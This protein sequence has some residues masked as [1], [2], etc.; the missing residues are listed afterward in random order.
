MK[1]AFELVAEFRDAQGKG[2]SRRLRHANKVPA[3]LY[4][5]HREPRALA[6]DHT[7]LLL[8][9]ENERFYSTIINLKVGDLSQAAI[10]K[11]VQRHPAKNAVVHV[12]LQRVLDDEKIRIKIPLHFKGEAGSP[13]VKKG[14]IVS[15]LR[16]EIEVTCLPKDLPEFVEVDLS[17]VD[18]NQM[19]YLADLKVPADVEIPELTHGRNSPVVSIHHAK[20]EVEPEAPAGEAGAV[21]ATAAPGAAPVA[22]PGAAPAAAKPAEAAKKDAKK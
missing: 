12:D 8:M 10:L 5:G 21:A 20:A 3:I 1:T 17:A 7:K 19:V 14:G 22:A 13:G 4:G 18:I 15:H 11:D 2:A 9:L 6:L 16:N